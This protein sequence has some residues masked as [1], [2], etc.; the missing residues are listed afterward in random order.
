MLASLGR[1]A[2]YVAWF[3]VAFRVAS[4]ALG[5]AVSTLASGYGVAVLLELGLTVAG[6]AILAS[7]AKRRNA[8]QQVLAGLLLVLGG[9]AYRF[10][11]YLVGFR[12]GS[13]WSYFP[14]VPELL[15]SFGIVALEI[16]LYVAAVR[17][18]PILAGA[19]APARA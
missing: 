7:G 2:S 19:Q 13:H 10:N 15:I 1:V 16:A 11:V 12:P 14:A 5:G 8:G 9:A 6:A 18:F 17:S 4:I 3:F